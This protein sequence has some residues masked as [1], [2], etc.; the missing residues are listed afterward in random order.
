MVGPEP[1]TPFN[2]GTS[3]QNSKSII[4]GHVSALNE[5]LKE[6]NNRNLIKPML[7]D[8]DDVQDVSDEEIEDG[9]KR[10]AKK[11]DEDL[12]KPFKEVLKC[13]FTRKI[14][15]FLS[16]G[17][18][19]PENAKIYDGTGDLED[20]I[21]RF[22]GI[23]NQGEWPMPVWC[24]MFQQT[25]DGKARAWFNKLP[26]GSIDNW[27]SFQEK[28]LNRFRMLKAYDKHPIQYVS[29]TLHDA[30][31]NYALLEKMVLALRHASRRLRKYFEDRLITVITDQPIKQILSKAD[32]SGRLAQYF[33]EL[34][35]YNIMYEPRN[36]IKGQILA[37]FINEMPVGSEAMAPQQTQY[38]IDHQKD[39]KE[40]WVLYTDEA[41]SA[42]GSGA[43]LVLISPTKAEYT[44][45]LRLNIHTP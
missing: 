5:L 41:S 12:S 13:P 42:K 20:H 29:R 36:A 8:F 31:R 43:G 19:P 14:I 26:P 1:I 35:A 22:V 44:Y 28:F 40:E 18:R 7:L 30:E 16:P 10:K 33:V 45:A 11:A 32:T 27:G 34:G 2:E 23:G 39:C 9:T 15:E 21:G 38:T 37:D 3:N 25:L 4:E 17:H 24:R 6:P